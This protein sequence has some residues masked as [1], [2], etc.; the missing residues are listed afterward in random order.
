MA[1]ATSAMSQSYYLYTGD[2][3]WSL[4]PNSYS[5]SRAYGF[6]V[7]SAG[8]L[9]GDNVSIK[10]GVRPSVSLAPGIMVV[11]GDG[12]SEMPYEVMLEDE[13]YG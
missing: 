2:N 4:S 9:I 8:S 6:N 13:V 12:S 10:G 1:G 7:Y 3:W 5:Y 11:N